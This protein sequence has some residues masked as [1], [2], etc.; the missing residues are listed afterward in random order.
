MSD[1]LQK[2]IDDLKTQLAGKD[3][4]IDGLLSQMDA[5]REVLNESMN[6]AMN[7]R[8][9][10]IHVKKANQKVAVE[11]DKEKKQ[12]ASLQAEYN[13]ALARIT[14]LDAEL[15]S[16]KAELEGLKQTLA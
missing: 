10:V 6:T 5:H 3:S 4:A 12:Y 16:V 9:N 15:A 13:N 11:L 2:E 8:T 1:A 14:A 7:L